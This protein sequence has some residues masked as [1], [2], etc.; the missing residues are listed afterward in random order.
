MSNYCHE[1][2]ILLKL[3]GIERPEAQFCSDVHRKRFR[4]SQTAQKTRNRAKTPI[5]KQGL[6][7]AQNGGSTDT[8]TAHGGTLETP[9][10]A[11]SAFREES[12]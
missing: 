8:L 10:S 11:G 3:V 1:C 9:V 12:F 7:E 6:T 2:G 5:A 4:K